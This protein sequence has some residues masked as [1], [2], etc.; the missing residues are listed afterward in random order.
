MPDLAPAPADLREVV[1]E[2]MK[3]KRAELIA[4]PL[5]RIWPDPTDAALSAI[6]AAGYVILPR[7]PVGYLWRFRDGPRRLEDP[8]FRF[9]RDA[10]SSR[11]NVIH[12]P[13]YAEDRAALAAKEAE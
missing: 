9:S 6:A 12:M 13:V 10:A 1:E 11:S 5:Q 2:A 3:A 8:F 7:E 4:A